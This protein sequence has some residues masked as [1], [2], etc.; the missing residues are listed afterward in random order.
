MKAEYF[1]V[2]PHASRSPKIKKCYYLSLYER[3]PFYGGP[4]EGGWWVEDTILEA[5]K[6]FSSV[7]RAESARRRVEELAKKNTEE[8]QAAYGDQC[9]RELDWLEERGLEANFLP[10]PDGPS[11]YFVV[12]EQRKGSLE[13]Q[14]TRGYE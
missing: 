1:E 4:E 8:A 11:Q 13:S 10:E 7:E 2:N 12:I 14:G 5:S 3:I 9:N 6:R